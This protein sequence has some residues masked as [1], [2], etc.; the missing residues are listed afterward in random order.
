[1]KKLCLNI[2]SINVY[3]KTPKTKISWTQL[4][5]GSWNKSS[6]I[7][8]LFK[9]LW[10]VLAY[11]PEANDGIPNSYLI[12]HHHSHCSKDCLNQNGISFNFFSP[13]DGTEIWINQRQVPKCSSFPPIMY[14][15]CFL[16]VGHRNTILY[17]LRFWHNYNF[18]LF[19]PEALL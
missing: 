18:I 15:S 4:K 8:I 5:Y 11:H 17:S 3:Q 9:H 19:S 10:L 2:C 7:S 6:N 1:M 14:L 13:Y 12:I 16:I